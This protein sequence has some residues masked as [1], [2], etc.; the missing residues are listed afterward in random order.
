MTTQGMAAF[1]RGRQSLDRSVWYSGWLLTFLA[2][3]EDTGGQFLLTEQTAA[4]AIIFWISLYGGASP[5]GGSVIDG[6]GTLHALKNPSAPAGAHMTRI[7][8][9]S[10]SIVNEC[11]MSRGA[12]TN[13]PAGALIVS[14]PTENVISPSIT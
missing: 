7:R 6:A 10:E 5:T 1:G 13:V 3:G 4:S 2:T 14:S 12:K 8:T 9:C 11:G